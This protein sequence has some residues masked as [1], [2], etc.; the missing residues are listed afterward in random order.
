VPNWGW[1][2]GAIF[3]K[4]NLAVRVAARENSFQSGKNWK[5]LES[6]WGIC[7]GLG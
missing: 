3:G 2:F 5:E 7:S 1:I 6:F 4:F